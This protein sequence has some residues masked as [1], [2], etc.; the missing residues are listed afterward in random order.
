M[1]LS[2]K[3]C[4]T[5]KKREKKFEILLSTILQLMSKVIVIYEMHLE[6]TVALRNTSKSSGKEENT[7]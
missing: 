2:C 7:I 4:S 6:A 3:L 1:N 5:V